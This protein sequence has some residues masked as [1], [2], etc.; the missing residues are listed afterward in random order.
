[1]NGVVVWSEVVDV[2]WDGIVLQ[3]LNRL[4]EAL[5]SN[6]KAKCWELFK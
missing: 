2:L 3:D 5:A 4:D 6:D 1:M